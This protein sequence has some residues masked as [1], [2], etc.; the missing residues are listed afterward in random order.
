MAS[1]KTRNDSAGMGKRLE[2]LL[3]ERGYTQARLEK[4]IG[5]SQGYL[6]R[7][8]KG[9]RGQKISPEYLTSIAS[10]LQVTPNFLRWGT[11]IE[12]GAIMTPTAGLS[13]RLEDIAGYRE[14]EFEVIRKNPTVAF[15]I[16]ESARQARMSPPPERI[17]EEYLTG[18]VR[19]L[20]S[21]RAAIDQTETVK[22]TLGKTGVTKSVR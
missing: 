13:P 18:L 19:F 17:T 15:Q 14:A 10:V 20:A 6:S 4:E 7:I 12:E 5:A 22:S 9:S 11:E 16:F 8:V 21:S 1:R 3:L 2:Q